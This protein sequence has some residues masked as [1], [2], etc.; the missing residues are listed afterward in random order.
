MEFKEN[1]K[2]KASDF[3][4]YSRIQFSIVFLATFQI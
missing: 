3:D 1:W 2:T 4:I